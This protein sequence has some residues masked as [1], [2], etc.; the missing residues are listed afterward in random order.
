[1]WVRTKDSLF[2]SNNS[3]GFFVKE[4]V[5]YIYYTDTY[6]SLNSHE[7]EGHEL[8]NHIFEQLSYG[9]FYLD[10]RFFKRF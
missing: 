8:L 4:G 10:I 2:N 3:K 6:Y 5:C 9:C 7:V 1:M